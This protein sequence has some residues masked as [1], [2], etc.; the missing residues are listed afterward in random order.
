MRIENPIEILKVTVLI[1]VFFSLFL[2]GASFTEVKQNQTEIIG[3]QRTILLLVSKDYPELGTYTGSGYQ[4]KN[5]YEIKVPKVG[6]LMK[7]E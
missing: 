2:I 3:N 5:G 1:V 4:D 7:G 6:T